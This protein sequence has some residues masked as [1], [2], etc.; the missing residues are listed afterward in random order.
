[1]IKTPK[2][3]ILLL[4][5]ALVICCGNTSCITTPAVPTALRPPGWEEYATPISVPELGISSVAIDYAWAGW[6]ER[7]LAWVV[8]KRDGEYQTDRGESVDAALV[9]ALGS[10]LTNL[11]RSGGLKSC[12]GHTDDYPH[13]R[14]DIIFEDGS[15]ATLL[16]DSNCP[17]NVP[18]NVV[19]DDNLYVQYTGEIP[20]A[21]H[22]LFGSLVGDSD[23]PNLVSGPAG[24]FGFAFPIISGELP[25]GIK[26]TGFSEKELY[27]QALAG[28][29]LFEPFASTYELGDL[30]LFCSPDEG[31]RNC[32]VIDGTVTLK[33]RGGSVIFSVP[34]KFKELE[35]SE[36]GFG[37][38][39]I[40]DIGEKIDRHVLAERV[41][42]LAP[43]ATL[44]ISCSYLSRCDEGSHYPAVYASLGLSAPSEC[45]PCTIRFDGWDVNHEFV[46]FPDLERIWV[47]GLHYRVDE[48]QT[49]RST[50]DL[51]DLLTFYRSPGYETLVD[52]HIIDF[53]IQTCHRMMVFYEPGAL[54]ANPDYVSALSEENA[55]NHGNRI[56][57]YDYCIFVNAQG[58]LEAKK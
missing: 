5:F 14:I 35:V 30:K 38:Q 37:I 15:E 53:E 2:T 9:S 36:I 25:E 49:N 41:R 50:L 4:T 17:Q 51:D 58:K 57:V 13:F 43:E 40:K 47:D 56:D 45:S 39:E 28:S 1:M 21:L 24:W 44:R 34:V 16:S 27:L 23:E 11:R 52:E 32:A 33:S 42:D 46:Y 22:T 3:T 19:Y 12:L 29:D 26:E 6:G 20:T 18:W 7:Q 54:E 8:E 55:E 48:F 10:S 31:N